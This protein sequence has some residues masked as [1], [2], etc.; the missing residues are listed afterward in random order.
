MQL[1]TK[2]NK[3]DINKEKVNE[4]FKKFKDGGV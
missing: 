3:S 1:Y 2:I 4:F